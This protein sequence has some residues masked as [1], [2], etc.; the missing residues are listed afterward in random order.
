MAAPTSPQSNWR[1]AVSAALAVAWALPVAAYAELGR[2]TRYMADDFCMGYVAQAAGFLGAQRYWYFEWSGR[3]TYT[4]LVGLTELFPGGLIP[5]LPALVLAAWF[6]A[7]AW[8]AAALPLAPAPGLRRALALLASGFVISNTLAAIPNLTQSLYWRGGVLTYVAPLALGTLLAGTLLRVLTTPRPTW[9]SYALIALLALAGSGFAEVYTAVQAGALG[10]A[11]AAALVFAPRAQRRRYAVPLAIALAATL[12]GLLAVAVAP[13]TRIRQADLAAAPG[14]LAIA[15]NSLL[16]T[17]WFVRDAFQPERLL[18][19]FIALTLPLAFAF[20]LSAGQPAPANARRLTLALM[21]LPLA[22]GALLVAAYATGFYALQYL[23]PDRV[24]VIQWFVV[25]TLSAAWGWL[26]GIRLAPTRLGAAYATLPRA[27]RT[28]LVALTVIL[29]VGLAALPTGTAQA[30]RADRQ[31]FARN[32]DNANALLRAQPP[33]SRVTLARLDNPAGIDSLSDDPTFWTNHCEGLYY[34]VELTAQTPPPTATAPELA[35]ARPVQGQLGDTAQVVGYRVDPAEA[36]PGAALTVTIYWQP[37]AL[38]DRP[39]TFFIHLLGAAGS[40]A[41][42]DA[43]PGQG[44]YPTTRW[45]V[46]RPFADTYTLTLP[47]AA[48]AGPAR[49]IV[50]LY[51]LDTLQRLPATGPAADPAG[52]AWLELGPVTV[53]P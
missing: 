14:L 48:T 46:G 50:G 52:E 43:Y 35:A 19:W 32:W 16:Y 24:L 51:D 26:A 30:L 39:Y 36:R 13:G 22:L 23:P 40:V 47:A 7:L 6:A 3:Y 2:Y 44:Q 8:A 1:L 10:L 12:L 5:A 11:L 17:G 34:G 4:L 27:A 31:Y 21:L 33:G 28:A 20:A 9:L 45:L 49:L 41:Q 29:L 37:L 15:H 38:T 25:L 53:A 42:V 18:P